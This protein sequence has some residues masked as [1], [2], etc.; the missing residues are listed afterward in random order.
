MIVLM[1][2]LFTFL[3]SLT[4]SKILNWFK[5]PKILEFSLI[6]VIVAGILIIASGLEGARCNNYSFLADAWLH[7]RPWINFQG[8]YIDSIPYNGH[9][10]IIEAPFPGLLTLPFVLL[11]G[12]NTLSELIPSLIVGTLT[13][14][15]FWLLFNRLGLI[16]KDRILL[17]FFKFIGTSLM[18]CSYL[19]DVWFFSPVVAVCCTG[20]ALLECTGKRRGWIIGLAAVCAFESRS[21]LAP[22]FLLYPYLIA[23]GSLSNYAIY[24]LKNIWKRLLSY[25]I[26][27]CIGAIFWVFY[28]EIRWGTFN[29]IGYQLFCNQDIQ[30]LQTPFGF[31]Y[32]FYEVYSFFMRPPDFITNGPFQNAV[33]P[34]FKISN[35]GLALLFC[36]PALI[37][38][39]W[40]KRNWTT[41]MIWLTSIL[42]LIPELLYYVNGFVQSGMRHALDF[43]PFLILLMALALRQNPNRKFFYILL[44]YSIMVGIWTVVIWKYTH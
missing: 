30:C 31:Q 25:F 40:A 10:Y 44:C 8:A 43:E 38:A 39:F 36:S 29:D 28:N 23:S 1:G 13:I 4:D 26:V 35:D 11:W 16:S 24:E 34:Y 6:T 7:F 21:I 17:S 14:S 37:I 20:I 9:H 19:G 18:W 3:I 12:T 42:I 33:F 15:I 32:F 41:I 5:K 27:L 2:A 22:A